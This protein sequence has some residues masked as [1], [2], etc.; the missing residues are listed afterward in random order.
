MKINRKTVEDIGIS[1][2]ILGFCLPMASLLW[3][4]T[5][6]VINKILGG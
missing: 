4:F 6:M 3:I 5:I 1:L 2:F